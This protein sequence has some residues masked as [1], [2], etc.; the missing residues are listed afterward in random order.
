L[1][2]SGL[3]AAELVTV[4]ESDTALLVRP[5]IAHRQMDAEIVTPLPGPGPITAFR[6]R[7]SL[8]LLNLEHQVQIEELPWVAAINA[9]RVDELLAHELSRQ[10][11]EQIV[12]LALTAFPQQILPNKLLQEIRALAEPSLP[13]VDEVAADIFMGD[14]SEK[15]LRAAQQAGMLLAGTWYHAVERR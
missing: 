15:Y 7:R 11:L 9:F 6:R 4:S 3:R 12:V 13:I 8:L 14:F 2:K 5:E 1:R 10:T